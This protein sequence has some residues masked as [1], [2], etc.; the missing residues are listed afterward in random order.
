MAPTRHLLPKGE[1][2]RAI[3]RIL[4]CLIS[5]KVMQQTILAVIQKHHA[6]MPKW[7]AGTRRGSAVHAISIP[8]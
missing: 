7:Q 2:R 5:V 3:M 4:K 1:G 8:A 6:A